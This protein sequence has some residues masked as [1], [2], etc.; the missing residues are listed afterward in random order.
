MSVR[1]KIKIPRMVKIRQKFPRPVCVDIA[2]EVKKEVA[3]F[4][5]KLSSGARVAIAVGSRGIS[6][7][8]EV[9]A[10]VV[11]EVK[12]CEAKP[13]IV[14]AMGSHGGATAEGQK[15]ILESYGINEHSVGAPI[16]SSMEVIKIGILDNSV[17]V[18]FDK[19]PLRQMPSFPLTELNPTLIFMT[20]LKVA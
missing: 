9:A 3:Q 14:P 7:I 18:Y 20:K 6:N 16:V 12:R 8:K 15:R 11:Q 1:E 5:H 17:P 4:L 2:S 10:A 13:F 19:K